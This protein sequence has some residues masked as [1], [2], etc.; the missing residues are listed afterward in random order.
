[1]GGGGVQ[2][3]HSESIK[4]I[5]SIFTRGREVTCIP[6]WKVKTKAYR[7]PTSQQQQLF[8]RPWAQDAGVPLR[9]WSGGSAVGSGGATAML[10]CF[11][12]S[13]WFVQR[14]RHQYFPCEKKA[15]PSLWKLYLSKLN[16][17]SPWHERLRNRRNIKIQ[18]GTATDHFSIGRF[19]KGRTARIRAFEPFGFEYKITKHILI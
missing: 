8:K 5:T 16:K 19:F 14:I 3:C 17:Y 13:L 9:L 11:I 7:I 6:F 18:H 15:H 4:H 2:S 12:T 1:M 10:I